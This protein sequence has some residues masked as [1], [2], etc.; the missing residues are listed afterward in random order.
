MSLVINMLYIS[1]LRRIEHEL[2]INNET[3]PIESDGKYHQL[4]Y[5]CLHA[6]NK[7]IR[8]IFWTV[9]STVL[10]RVDLDSSV[11]LLFTRLGNVYQYSNEEH[12]D[13]VNR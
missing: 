2:S 4:L 10:S 1:I 8:T 6:M 7:C 3:M 12:V 11:F 9:I 5:S 13:C